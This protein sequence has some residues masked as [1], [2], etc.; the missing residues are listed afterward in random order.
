M[1]TCVQTSDEATKNS[2][3]VKPNSV[4]KPNSALLVTTGHLQST[5]LIMSRRARPVCSKP[6]IRQIR[7]G[8]CD[9]AL[10]QSARLYRT[11]Q[12]LKDSRERGTVVGP[13]LVKS[14]Y[15]KL[16]FGPGWSNSHIPRILLTII[17]L[18]KAGY[19]L[20]L[21][22]SLLAGKVED[23]K[24]KANDYCWRNGMQ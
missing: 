24:E 21:G 8:G 5:N 13:S 9:T 15:R 12:P 23:T 18:P 17:H 14:S 11:R 2:A 4:L 16:A 22:R 10:S 3:I 20:T 7:Y 6:D 1:C 19:G